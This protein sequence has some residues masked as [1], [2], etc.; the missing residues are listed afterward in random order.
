MF[1]V[2]DTLSLKIKGL[3]RAR[4]APGGLEQEGPEQ[5]RGPLRVAWTDQ[6]PAQHALWRRPF[7]ARRR[8]REICARD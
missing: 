4:P 2:F 6:E 8:A 1:G 5:T 3:R 7:A